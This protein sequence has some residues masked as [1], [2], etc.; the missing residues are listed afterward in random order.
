MS[1][2][3][4]NFENDPTFKPEIIWSNGNRS[5]PPV[6]VSVLGLLGTGPFLGVGNLIGHINFG[7]TH[8]VELVTAEGEKVHLLDSECYCVIQESADAAINVMSTGQLAPADPLEYLAK[9][10]EEKL[11]QGSPARVRWLK[12]LGIE[13]DS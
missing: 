6:L 12:L 9:F 4:R 7:N 13:T 11:I 10:E 8:V 5:N 1:D 3:F 2:I